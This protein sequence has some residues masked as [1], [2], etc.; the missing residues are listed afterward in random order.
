MRIAIVAHNGSPL[1]PSRDPHADARAAG[2]TS[3]AQT[4]A[5]SGHRVTIYARRDSRDLPD[6]AIISR[7]VTIEHLSAGPAAP[8]DDGKLMVHIKDF[9][10]QLAKRWAQK[11]PD[12]VHAQNWTSGLATLVAGRGKPVRIVQSF[13][14]LASAERRHRLPASGPEPRARLEACLARSADCVVA[15]TSDEAAELVKMGVARASI[16][17]VPTGVDT[18]LFSPE[19]ARADRTQRPRLLAISPLEPGQGLDRLVRMLTAIPEAE[20]VIAG[21]PPKTALRSNEVYRELMRLARDMKVQRR[22]SFTG[23]VRHAELPAL[24][25]SAD[26]LVST[27]PYE[28]LGAITIAAMACGIPAA[29]SAVGGNRDAVLDECTGLLVAPGRTDLLARRVRRLL[30]T[31]MRL[32]AFGIAAADRAGARYGADRIGQETLAAYE[33]L[34]APQTAQVA[35]PAQAT[36]GP[37]EDLALA[38]VHELATALA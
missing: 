13:D 20:L 8:L 28:P 32:E 11:C 33:R 7:G 27:A 29:V 36:A 37:D 5:S 10:D 1:T 3:L 9:G 22:I 19:G 15:S 17:V 35:V 6:H 2:M 4:L 18:A 14:T 34:V 25:R 30:A 12:I 26:L 16:A 38:P 24:L 21:G 23:Q 31:P